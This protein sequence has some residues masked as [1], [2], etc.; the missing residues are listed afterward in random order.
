MNAIFKAA[1]AIAGLTTLSACGGSSDTITTLP[2]MP[3]PTSY[4]TLGLLG[5]SS[6][7]A[8]EVTKAGGNFMWFANTVA[9]NG[10][11][12]A[13]PAVVIPGTPATYNGSISLTRVLPTP[14]NPAGEIYYGRVRM[15][16]DFTTDTVDGNIGNFGRVSVTSSGAAQSVP[17][18][19][20][21]SGTISGTDM[22][23][24]ANFGTID[25]NTV[26]GPL[27]GTFFTEKTTGRNVVS[28]SA[29]FS[30]GS[31]PNA[32]GLFLASE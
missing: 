26:S 10:F 28:G 22:S 13:I 3:A 8:E 31:G 19:V 18:L 17:G 23:A 4:Q 9:A 21:F 20:G 1:A 2:A 12:A 15:D 7:T 24:L 6:W 32:G 25:G 29:D 30:F 11:N 14:S 5:T 16:A 27:N